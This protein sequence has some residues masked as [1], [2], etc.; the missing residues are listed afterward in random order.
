MTLRRAGVLFVLGSVGLA[1]CTGDVS[2]TPTPVIVTASTRATAPD[3]S[4]WIH[5]KYRQEGPV[6]VSDFEHH[7]PYDDPPVDEAWYDAPNRYMIVNLDGTNYHYCQFTR[8]DWDRFVGASDAAS[9]YTSHIRGDFDCRDGGVP[10]YGGNRQATTVTTRA[11]SVTTQPSRTTTTFPGDGRTDLERCTHDAAVA[12]TVVTS[13]AF[14]RAMDILD[15]PRLPVFDSKLDLWIFE[16]WCLDDWRGYLDATAHEVRQQ[17]GGSD[18]DRFALGLSDAELTT[19]LGRLCTYL[20]LM[21][22]DPRTLYWVWDS[23]MEFGGFSIW[24]F[25]EDVGTRGFLNVIYDATVPA[26][27]RHSNLVQQW[28]GML[29]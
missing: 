18:A 20:D 8:I 16:A 1:A 28:M 17:I 23:R 5:V 25:L 11:A 3:G 10:S 27:P 12:W 6:D 13:D 21:E 2:P 22:G 29:H 4:L 19:Q 14:V 15:D 9:Y 24:T 26:C 7:R